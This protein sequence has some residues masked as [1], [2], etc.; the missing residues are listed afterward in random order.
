MEIY[1][2]IKARRKEIGLSA[3]DVAASL[4]VSRATI[5]R[6]ESADIEKLPTTIIEPLAKVLRCSV[7]YL[8]GWE[9]TI[10]LSSPESELV[11]KYRLLNPAGKQKLTERADELIDLGYTEK[12]DGARMA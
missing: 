6:Y 3:D 2:R 1:E 4:G 5:Y 9:S 11:E 10:P 7:S 12:G 8:M